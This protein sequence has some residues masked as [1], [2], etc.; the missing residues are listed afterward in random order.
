MTRTTQTTVPSTKAQEKHKAAKSAKKP[1]KTVKTVAK[2]A[3]GASAATKKTLKVKVIKDKRPTVRTEASDVPAEKGERKAHKKRRGRGALDEILRYQSK[4]KSL[5]QGATF[6]RE[7][8]SVFDRET[9]AFVEL[10]GDDTHL[11]EQGVLLSEAAVKSMRNAQEHVQVRLLERAQQL[12]L[13]EKG[14]VAPTI[15]HLMQAAVQDETLRSIVEDDE[16]LSGLARRQVAH[17]QPF[18]PNNMLRAQHQSAL[19]C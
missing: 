6:R 13:L 18:V 9:E 14:R 8:R 12:A 10:A 15:K 1:S 4:K 7:L 11:T 17:E 2:I 5:I 3:G 19:Y 16:F